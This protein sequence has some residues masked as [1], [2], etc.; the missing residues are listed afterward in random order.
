MIEPPRWNSEQF[1]KDRQAAIA[2]FRHDRLEEP[3]ESYLDLFDEY[4]GVFEEL[5]EATVDLTQLRD[6]GLQVLGNEKLLQAFRY[7]GGPPI[8]TD[9]LKTLA[10]ATSL[11]FRHLQQDPTLVQKI[12]DIALV[13]LDRRRFPWVSEGRCP[14]E[15]ELQAAA[16][17]SA[18]L[19][20]TQRLGTSRRN[21]GKKAQE[22]RVEDALLGAGFQKVPTRYIGQLPLAPSAGEFCGE[23]ML[24]TR[25]ADF[26]I[27]L[28]DQR[29][30]ALECKV[31][32]SALNSVKRLNNDAAA[33]AEAWRRDFGET[34][35][36]PSAVIS[37]VYK[38]HKLQEAQRR[39]LTIFWSHTLTTLLDWIEQTRPQS[40]KPR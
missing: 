5:L 24:G 3:L 10:E 18:A 29:V 32:N 13:A 20:A 26:V 4:Q 9:D 21:E 14:T 6:S 22:R 12:I 2:I 23:S 34:Q 28:W 27:R 30:L 37:G 17:A 33:K 38:L 7:L 39:G 8:S 19:I 15:P 40:K 1:E 11:N 36:V 31:S 16:V 25:K 35:I